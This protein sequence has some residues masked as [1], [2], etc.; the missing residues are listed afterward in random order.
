[1]ALH[2]SFI[3]GAELGKYI[4]LGMQYCSISPA[5]VEGANRE[6]QGRGK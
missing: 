5:Q 2:A 3:L 4:V 6:Y 1:M